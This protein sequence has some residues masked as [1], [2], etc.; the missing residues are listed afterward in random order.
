MATRDCVFQLKTAMWD[1][2]QECF[3]MLEPSK[4]KEMAED[5]SKQ[6]EWIQ[7]EANLVTAL[8]AVEEKCGALKVR[9]VWCC[10]ARPCLMC[11]RA[12]HDC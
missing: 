4:V 9:C 12:G 5:P 10:E 6:Q 2:L 7:P 8:A 1:I 3:V 11:G